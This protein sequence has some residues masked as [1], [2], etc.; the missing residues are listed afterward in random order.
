[1]RCVYMFREGSKGVRWQSLLA[2]VSSLVFICLLS[3]FL[4]PLRHS[5]KEEEITISRIFSKPSSEHKIFRYICLKIIKKKGSSCTGSEGTK[6]SHPHVRGEKNYEIH[7]VAFIA[8]SKKKS[9]NHVA[10]KLIHKHL[11]KWLEFKSLHIQ[12]FS[13]EQLVAHRFWSSHL[14][15]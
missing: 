2:P 12:K 14:H 9:F 13:L 11:R 6:V 4:L 7:Y 5:K 10:F 1:M 3:Y 15:T 8:R